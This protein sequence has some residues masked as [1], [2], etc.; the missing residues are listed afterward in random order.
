MLEASHALELLT[1]IAPDHR[2]LSRLS[3]ITKKS[4]QQLVQLRNYPVTVS[5]REGLKIDTPRVDATQLGKL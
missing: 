1:A 3:N 2:W 5:K 4:L